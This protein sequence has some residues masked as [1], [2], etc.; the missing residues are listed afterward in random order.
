MTLRPVE[1]H[2][3]LALA[4]EERHGYGHAA[5]GG[6]ASPTASC[7]SSRGR[8]TAPS[9]ACSSDGW[10]V[11]SARRPAADLDDERRRYYRMTPRGPARRV[12]R[13]RA[14]VAAR[15]RGPRAQVADPCLMC[16]RPGA[17]AR[18]VA[19]VRAYP[20]RFR[21]RSSASGWWTRS[22]I[23]C[24]PG[25]RRARRPLGVWVPAIVDTLG[26]RRRNGCAR[27]SICA[28][29]DDTTSVRLEPDRGTDHSRRWRRTMMDKLWQDVRYAL[30]LWARRPGVRAGRHPHARARHRRQHRDVQHRQRRAAAPAA[31]SRMP[32]ASSSVWGRTQA[33]PRTSDLMERVR[34]DR[35]PRP[36]RSMRSPCG[37]AEREPDR[38]RR[39]RSASSATS[40]TGIVLRRPRAEG[41]A[42]ALCSAKRTSR[43]GSAKPVVVISH[44]FWEQQFNSDPSAIGATMTSTACR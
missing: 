29:A 37:S 15:H 11:E 32:I 41:R 26:T 1:F 13:G 3:L 34:G 25:A 12:G 40:S 17:A 24:V 30:R 7:R 20:P 23:G 18:V 4:A 43:W 36:A 9:I 19:R 42:R 10:V 35:Q 8:C 31:V 14:P 6:A 39:S 22:R 38:R 28:A 5:G 27:R 21:P 2:I 16:Q 44:A 33:N